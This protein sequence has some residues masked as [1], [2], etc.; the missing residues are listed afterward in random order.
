[1]LNE[2]EFIQF[3]LEKGFFPNGAYANPNKILNDKQLRT[4][5]KSYEKAELKKQEKFHNKLEQKIEDDQN[6]EFEIDEKWLELKDFVLNRDQE[7][8]QFLNCLSAPE[9]QIVKK[10]IWGIN[11]I[12]DGA[13][14]IG[15]AES[16]KL[17]YESYNVVILCRYAH[18]MIDTYRDPITQKSM[19]KEERNNWWVRI[20][21]QVR[22]DELNLMK[23]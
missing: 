2:K 21:G 18:S 12:L 11:A 15:R 5:Y 4:K 23:R 16:L 8:C 1:M 19:T 22:F 13:H 9:Y 17:K 10:H 6:A 20:V 7:R 14:I 3:Y